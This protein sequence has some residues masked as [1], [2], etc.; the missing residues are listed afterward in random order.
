MVIG[1]FYKNETTK[2]EEFI[3]KAKQIILNLYND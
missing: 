3:L 2:A 1:Y